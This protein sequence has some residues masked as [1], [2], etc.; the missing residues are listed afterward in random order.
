MITA[1]FSFIKANYKDVA[2]TISELMGDDYPVKQ[3]DD[4]LKI[5]LL[6]DPNCSRQARMTLWSPTANL[7]SS[8]TSERD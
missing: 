1:N 5:D 8:R 3:I 4:E 7:L 2:K 6:P